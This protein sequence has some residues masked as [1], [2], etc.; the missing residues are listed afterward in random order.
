MHPIPCLEVGKIRNK[1][2]QMIPTINGK[3]SI[4]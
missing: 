2:L 3:L 4:T 1:P